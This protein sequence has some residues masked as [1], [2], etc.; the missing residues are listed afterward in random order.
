MTE[1]PGEPQSTGLQR[2]DATEE[3]GTMCYINRIESFK[4]FRDCH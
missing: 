2:V 3:T 4:S 1:E